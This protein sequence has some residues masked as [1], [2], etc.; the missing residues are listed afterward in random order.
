[1]TQPPKKPDF[2]N[3]RADVTSTEAPKT[4]FS[5]VQS[6]VTS[7]E[8][9]ADGDGGDVR[10]HTV[11]RGDTLS[12]IAKHYYGKASQYPKIFEAN[13]D[14]LDNPD[15]IKPGQVLKIPPLDDGAA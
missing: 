6:T 9:E 10:T 1:M 7:S 3:V 14:Q 11:V 13:R 8:H 12:K 4:D 5:N 2:S 15:R